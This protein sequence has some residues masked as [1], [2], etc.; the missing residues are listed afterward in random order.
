MRKIRVVPSSRLSKKKVVYA[1]LQY[2]FID[3]RKRIVVL[4]NNTGKWL[5][6]SRELRDFPPKVRMEFPIWQRGL[7][8]IVR[9]TK[10]NR[11][12]SVLNCSIPISWHGY[13]RRIIEIEGVYDD[14]RREEV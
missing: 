11:A 7:V 1:R 13:T 3:K 2:L 4:D 9:Y 10:D 6:T 14:R 12:N 8:F 5:H